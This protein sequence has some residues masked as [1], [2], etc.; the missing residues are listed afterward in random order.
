MTERENLFA[1][2]EPTLPAAGYVGYLSLNRETDGSVTLTVRSR[3]DGSQGTITVPQAAA[4][5]LAHALVN[6]LDT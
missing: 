1:Y 5:G 3:G 2:T 6:V 4:Q